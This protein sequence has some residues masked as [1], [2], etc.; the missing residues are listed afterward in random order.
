MFVPAARRTQYRSGGKEGSKPM[1]KKSR[2]EDLAGT[3]TISPL[4]YPILRPNIQ[5]LLAWVRSKTINY[6][7]QQ[8][9]GDR[10]GPYCVD[11]KGTRSLTA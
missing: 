1:N 11:E 4:H 10:R 5:R 8:Y 7:Q 9:G 2:Q 6:R 3:A